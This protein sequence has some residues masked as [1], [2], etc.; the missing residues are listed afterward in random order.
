MN[1]LAHARLS[2]GN[3]EIL[4]GNI[5]SDFVKGKKKFD[6]PL[7]VQKGIA[8]HRAIDSFTD[9]HE[10]SRKAKQVFRPH[11]RLYGGVFV[12][13]TYDHFL[14]LDGLEFPGET[15]L[16]FSHQVYHTLEGHADHLPARFAALF[17]YMK[18]HNWLFHYRETE[19]IR[20]SFEGI[21]RRARYVSEA[22]TAFRLFLQNY[23]LLH[24]C[25]RQ[26]W[27]DVKPFALREFEFL[28]GAGTGNI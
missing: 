24:D 10:A 15:L 14:A 4:V 6:Y 16:D 7:A 3:P 21:A 8:L 13:I 9:T 27:T 25:Y 12:D 17:P 28:S 1:Y 11:Y 26:F 23:Q 2:F 5:I 20:R 22:E 19:G 18:R